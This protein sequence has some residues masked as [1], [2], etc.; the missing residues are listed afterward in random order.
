MLLGYQPRPVGQTTN[1][2]QALQYLA[3][4]QRELATSLASLERETEAATA[5][6]ASHATAIKLVALYPKNPVFE[7]TLRRVESIRDK[8]IVAGDTPKKD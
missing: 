8:I 6:E 7:N 4:T 1:H 3:I 5:I 2:G